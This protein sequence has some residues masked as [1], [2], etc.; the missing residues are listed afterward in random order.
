MKLE[1]MQFDCEQAKIFQVPLAAWK[2]GWTYKNK[3]LHVILHLHKILD[4]NNTEFF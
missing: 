2:F 1:S 4:F 3:Y